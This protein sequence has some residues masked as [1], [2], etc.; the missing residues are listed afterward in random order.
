MCISAAVILRIGR[1]FDVGKRAGK[2]DLPPPDMVSDDARTEA[3]GGVEILGGYGEELYGLLVGTLEVVDFVN[4]CA[5][6][7]SLSP[8][9]SMYM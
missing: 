8:L 9:L 2:F 6:A 4:K 5:S 7:M 3:T 1:V